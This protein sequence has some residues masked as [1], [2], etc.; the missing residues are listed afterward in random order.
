[1]SSADLRQPLKRKS[2]HGYEPSLKVVRRAAF[3]ILLPCVVGSSALL[4]LDVV[5]SG[6][7]ISGP[8]L[9][10]CGPG[11]LDGPWARYVSNVDMRGVGTVRYPR[12]IP[13]DE[14]S[15]KQL[16]RRTLTNLYNDRPTWLDQ[17]HRKLDEAVFA[18]YGWDYEFSD[19]DIIA[20]LLALNT[21]RAALE[22]SID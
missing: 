21:E 10:C 9:S 20:R 19:D 14:L 18:A 11:S 22:S 5:R 3:V 4:P 15:A 6:V 8:C 2:P 7:R 17:A 16:A 1:M 12:L 13:K